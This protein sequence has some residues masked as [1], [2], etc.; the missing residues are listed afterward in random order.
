MTIYVLVMIL[1]LSLIS[2]SLDRNNPLDPA[3]DSSINAPNRV[4]GLS[5]S[6]IT[7]P[8]NSVV[9]SWNRTSEV[10]GYYVYRALSLSSVQERIATIESQDVIEFTD[11]DNIISGRRYF[12]WVSSY[13]QY[14]AGKLEGMLSERLELI[15]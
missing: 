6:R 2:C 7:N 15:F 13:I 1:S 4:T 9:L 10:D 8:V 5:F 12:Y 11:S 3:A 14:P